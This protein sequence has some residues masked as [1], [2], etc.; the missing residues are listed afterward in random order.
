MSWSSWLSEIIW[1]TIAVESTGAVG[2]LILQFRRQQV[3]EGA[4]DIGG[5]SAR[6]RSRGGGKCWLSRSRRFFTATHGRRSQRIYKTVGK[7]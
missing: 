1:P 7:V 3:Q 6:A 2:V 4:A 5:R